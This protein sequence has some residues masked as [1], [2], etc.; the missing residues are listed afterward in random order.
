ML[1][2]LVSV[3]C[4]DQL[5]CIGS[6]LFSHENEVLANRRQSGLTYDPPPF[7]VVVNG[8]YACKQQQQR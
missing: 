2:C 3:T 8:G 1:S 7:F 4:V 5:L 6:F